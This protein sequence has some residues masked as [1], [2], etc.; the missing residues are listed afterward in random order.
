[1]SNKRRLIIVPAVFVLLVIGWQL[2]EWFDGYGFNEIAPIEKIDIQ[3]DFENISHD[4]FREQVMA[5]I[6]AGYYSLDLD[7][8]RTT[9]MSLPW[10]DDVS[11]RRQWPSSLYI[12]VTEKRAVAY[13]NDDA[14]ISDRGDVFKPDDI[15]SKRLLPKLNGPEGLHNKM[16]MFLTI[17][18]KDFSL[19]GFEVVDLKLD[20]RRA[21]SFRFLSGNVS[22]EI[23][24]KLGRD[25][26]EDRLARFVRVFSNI[27]KFNLKN[28]EVIDLRYPNGFA[29]KIKNNIANRHLLVKEA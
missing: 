26:A 5:V 8:M 3:G 10:V 27:D 28:T 14:M 2:T 23:V 12:K 25:H 7:A 22:D 6:N 21:W 15:Q 29:M 16:W 18:N 24:V 20:D 11:V 17:I 19:M 4:A 13:W 9:L 1:M